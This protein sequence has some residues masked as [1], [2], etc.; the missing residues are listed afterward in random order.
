VAPLAST[1][2][3]A[4]PPNEPRKSWF[5]GAWRGSFQAEQFR[6]DLA[7]AGG[8]KEWKTDDGKQASG[9]G[10]LALQVAADGTVSGS[11]TGALGELSVLGRFEDDRATLT[12]T[13]ATPGGLHG[14]VVATR[15]GEGLKGMLSASSGDSLQV[16]RADV[17][18]SR[19]TP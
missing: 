11:G 5:E 1:V 6:M 10:Q 8:V 16:R 2:A 18:L 17:T 19:V 9:P 13:P 4:T 14:V 3:S 15:E 12:L 7:A